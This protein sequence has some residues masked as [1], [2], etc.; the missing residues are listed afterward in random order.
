MIF[1]QYDQPGCQIS[2]IQT[3]LVTGNL[4]GANLIASSLYRI[5]VMIWTFPGTTP[6]PTDPN[7]L[8]NP[9][10]MLSLVQR[11]HFARPPASARRYACRKPSI[12]TKAEE[13]FL[14][15][16]CSEAFRSRQRDYQ[17]PASGLLLYQ[18]ETKQYQA[19]WLLLG[20]PNCI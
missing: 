9:I 16:P 14:N 6:S 19:L 7:F 18:G 17:A 12:T 13:K 15:I 8:P 4:H 20:L 3:R 11:I 2:L 10:A 5:T 1:G